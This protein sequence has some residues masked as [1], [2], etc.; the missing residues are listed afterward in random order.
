MSNYQKRLENIKNR[1]KDYKEIEPT[2]NDVN[3][4][5]KNLKYKDL[6]INSSD[7]EFIKFLSK[8]YR[9]YSNQKFLNNIIR[10]N[11]KTVKIQEK[12]LEEIYEYL[13]SNRNDLILREK[14][15]NQIK[16]RIL[17]YKKSNRSEIQKIVNKLQERYLNEK[18]KNNALLVFWKEENFRA[19]ENNGFSYHFN[20]NQQFLHSV[21][22]GGDV[23]T[24]TRIDS[25]IKLSAHLKV[26]YQSTN[27]EDF[28]FGKY[29]IWADE[30]KSTYFSL[31]ENPDFMPILNKLESI[32]P[33]HGDNASKW[34]QAFQQIR[35]ISN[36]KDLDL[37]NNFAKQLKVHEK[38]NSV[39]R[40]W[41]EIEQEDTLIE[42]EY[43]Q[44][45]IKDLREKVRSSTD[46]EIKQTLSV[47]KVFLRNKHVRVY[48]KLRAGGECECC[49]NTAPFEKQNGRKYLEVHH[50]KSL[51]EG[52][53]DI[54]MNV[55]AICP[56]CHRAL[57]YSINRDKLRSKV[58]KKIEIKE[59]ENFN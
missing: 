10:D 52:G 51:S 9:K 29:R 50:I 25:E 11:N 40:S 28:E 41:D 43:S 14:E 56:N 35:V 19:A 13:L 37:I 59:Y 57:H 34:A 26:V 6:K 32:T 15:W 33:K 12:I 8:G 54:P 42:S 5:L 46:S 2:I 7:Y 47:Q 38:A 21:K 31:E 16:K 23:Y 45:D 27:S 20:S 48:A 55:A 53:K 1:I 24:M 18:F 4:Q 58:E 22:R 39:I 36:E 49:G 17:E 3:D 44:E 30:E